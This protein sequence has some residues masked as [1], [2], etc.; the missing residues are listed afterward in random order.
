MSIR[1]L[2]Y[3][4]AFPL[5]SASVPSVSVVVPA[6]CADLQKSFLSTALS[7]A[8]QTQLP[9]EVVVIASGCPPKES[10]G[11]KELYRNVLYP[12][13]LKIHDMESKQHEAVSRNQGANVSKGDIILFMDADDFMVPEYVD[14]I[15]GIFQKTNSY[16]VLHSYYSGYIPC[17][18]RVAKISMDS[19]SLYELE[20][21]T[22]SRHSWLNAGIHHAHV[23]VRR[24][25]MGWVQFKEIPGEDSR[26]VRDAI[27]ELHARNKEFVY[28]P[29][30]LSV[31]IGRFF[32]KKPDFFGKQ[33]SLLIKV[34][35]ADCQ[36]MPISA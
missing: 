22:R 36:S 9:D 6:L 28:T 24:Q 20:S 35:G 4:L 18:S 1:S 8:K 34:L 30:K 15:R 31:Y 27:V 5:A 13:P 17:G 12:I 26:F 11:L 3:F 29:A 14:N 16:M 23:S 25:V 19:A 32:Q 2:V 33:L 21:K 7:L 10:R